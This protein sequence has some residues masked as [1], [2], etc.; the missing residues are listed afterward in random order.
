MKLKFF[1]RVQSSAGRHS[2]VYELLHSFLFGAHERKCNVERIRRPELC[3][4]RCSTTRPTFGALLYCLGNNI[5]RICRVINYVV[6]AN[7]RSSVMSAFCLFLEFHRLKCKLDLAT[8]LRECQ[9]L[10]ERGATRPRAFK[11]F[12]Y[13]KEA[14]KSK[15]NWLICKISS[16]VFSQINLVI[17]WYLKSYRKLQKHFKI[18]MKKIFFI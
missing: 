13:V 18:I 12:S 2:R 1:R 7:D 11:R 5:R 17:A 14:E 4:D 8:R 10:I 9:G 15:S 3:N 16:C 6:C